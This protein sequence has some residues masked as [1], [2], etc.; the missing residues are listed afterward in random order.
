[1][2]NSRAISEELT[3]QCSRSEHAENSRAVPP[4]D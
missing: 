3:K 1:V 2:P 4:E